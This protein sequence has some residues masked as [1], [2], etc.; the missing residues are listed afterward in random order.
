[1][2]DTMVYK[3]YHTK[4]QYSDKDKYFY[5]KILGINDTISFHG[6]SVDEFRAAFEE[7]VDDYIALCEEIGKSPGKEYSGQ[8]VLRVPKEVHRE[9]VIS[10]EKK[11]ISLNAFV[12]TLC[13]NYLAK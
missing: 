1:M 12:T 4:P 2:S 5:G 13:E 3:G 11:G 8:F 9:L 6:Y 7:A 10:A